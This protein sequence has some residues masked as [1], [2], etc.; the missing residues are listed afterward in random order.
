MSDKGI[1]PVWH[2]HRDGEHEAGPFEDYLDAIGELHRLQ[3]QSADWAIKHEGW[4]IVSVAPEATSA[5]RYFISNPTGHRLFAEEM[6]THEDG[7]LVNWPGSAAPAIFIRGPQFEPGDWICDFCNETILTTWGAEHFPVPM[8]GS[9]A[10]CARH[11]AEE[12]AERGPWPPNSCACPPCMN[13]TEEWK[14]KLARA[15]GIA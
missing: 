15:L 11:Y 12:L 13:Q 8:S 7:D 4:A 2:I 10:L 3:G 14:P 5:D 9:N 6:N 1:Q